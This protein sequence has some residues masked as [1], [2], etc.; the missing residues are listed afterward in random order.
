[1]CINVCMGVYNN[2]VYVYGKIIIVRSELQ[3]LCGVHIFLCVSSCRAYGILLHEV[4]SFGDQPYPGQSN[5][6]VLQFVTAGGRLP[7]PENCPHKM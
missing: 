3:G 6:D 4:M 2:Y 7:K 1:M 5:Q